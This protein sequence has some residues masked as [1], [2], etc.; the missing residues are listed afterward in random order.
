[1]CDQ[2]GNQDSEGEKL[3]RWKIFVRTRPGFV[4]MGE[5]QASGQ[6]CIKIYFD[7]AAN[8]KVSLPEH[9]NGRVVIQEVSG[10]IGFQ[11]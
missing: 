9:P 1:M 7:T 11:F 2:P 3:D 5:S 6:P 8:A 4:A 10:T